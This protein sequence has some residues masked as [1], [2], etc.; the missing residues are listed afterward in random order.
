MLFLEY[1]KAKISFCTADS[2]LTRQELELEHWAI[3]LV[4]YSGRHLS[5]QHAP[6]YI[7]RKMANYYLKHF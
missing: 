4:S 7:V 5:P 2:D 3:V 6:A 1:K